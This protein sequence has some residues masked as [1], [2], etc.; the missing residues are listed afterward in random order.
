VAT[1]GG[2]WAVLLTEATT[3]PE[4]TLTRMRFRIGF[5]GDDGEIHLDAETFQ[6]EHDPEMAG[7][8]TLRIERVVDTAGDGTAEAF[9]RFDEQYY[10]DTT[11]LSLVL[12]YA[13]GTV[14]S[15][16]SD[17]ASDEEEP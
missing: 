2:A 3:E 14:T 4:S 9:I 16:R 11:H 12:T 1:G 13:G 10:E 6:I 7:D 8:G 17:R 15:S 5:V